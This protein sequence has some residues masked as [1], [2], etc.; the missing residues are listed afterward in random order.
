MRQVAAL[1]RESRMREQTRGRERTG[2]R[3]LAATLRRHSRRDVRGGSCLLAYRRLRR[4]GSIAAT[5][6][7]QGGHRRH[8]ECHC[9]PSH[10]PSP[11]HS[12]PPRAPRSLHPPYGPPPPHPTPPP[13]HTTLPT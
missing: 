11:S 10:F 7:L 9:N 3:T 8:A 13:P 1:L 2:R 12:Y 6:E 4:A 5:V